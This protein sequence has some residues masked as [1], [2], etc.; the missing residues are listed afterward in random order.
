MTAVLKLILPILLCYP[1][2]PEADVGQVAVEVDPSY[3]YF[4]T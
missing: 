4:I 1:L 3:Q 2:M